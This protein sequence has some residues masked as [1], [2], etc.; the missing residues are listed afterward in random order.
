MTAT[1]FGGAQAQ[2]A[3]GALV[4]LRQSRLLAVCAR[5]HSLRA[6]RR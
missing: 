5:R 4:R 6:L 1:S 2:M 3:T